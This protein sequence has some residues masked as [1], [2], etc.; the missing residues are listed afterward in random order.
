MGYGPR[1]HA[2]GYGASPHIEAGGTALTPAS[3]TT[4]KP[5]PEQPVLTQQE[6]RQ[7]PATGS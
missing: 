4:H 7:S 6:H 2:T 1:L 3:D 5:Q